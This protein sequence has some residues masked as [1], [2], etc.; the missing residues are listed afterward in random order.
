MLRLGCNLEARRLREGAWHVLESSS[1]ARAIRQMMR[2]GGVQP[3]KLDRGGAAAEQGAPAKIGSISVQTSF[4]RGFA[5]WLIRHEVGL[6]TS[7]YQ[8]G[9]LIFVGASAAGQPVLSAA[10][11]P[12][13]MGLAA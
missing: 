13:A 6:V 2:P 9:H 4:S 1:P 3:A 11:F 12:P 5:D 8:T 10:G 7:T